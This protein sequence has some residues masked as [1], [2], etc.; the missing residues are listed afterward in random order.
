MVSF[1]AEKSRGFIEQKKKHRS[2]EAPLQLLS[3][4][5]FMIF[6][7]VPITQMESSKH[8]S[9]CCLS[10]NVHELTHHFNQCFQHWSS[11]CVGRHQSELC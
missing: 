5:S 6:D 1:V 3:Q 10:G 8:R 9:W 2:V 4:I 7:V 11:R